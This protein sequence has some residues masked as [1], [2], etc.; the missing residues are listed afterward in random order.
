[1]AGGTVV[2]ERGST[3]YGKGLGEAEATECWDGIGDVAEI[4]VVGCGLN[5]ELF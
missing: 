1:M 2:D 4:V 3:V 5:G